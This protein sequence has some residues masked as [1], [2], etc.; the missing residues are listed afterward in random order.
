MTK[1]QNEDLEYDEQLCIFYFEIEDF[2]CARRICA[3]LL[4]DD[5]QN[6]TALLVL[7]LIEEDLGNY[8]RAIDYYNKILMVYVDDP[9]C[10]KR[11]A[12]AELNCKNNIQAMVDINKSIDSDPNDP[13]AYIIR[14]MLHFHSY[15]RKKEAII[16]YNLALKIDPEN[17]CGLYNRG[18]TFLR[19]GNK[20]YAYDDLRKAAKLGDLESEVLLKK[21]FPEKMP[22]SDR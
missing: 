6:Y 12:Y 3:E 7:G 2:K 4:E 21:Y 13:E 5:K 11:K 20:Q 16:D 15:D 18:L 19:I 10:L 17:I 14:G 1:E 22:E 9:Q 8:L